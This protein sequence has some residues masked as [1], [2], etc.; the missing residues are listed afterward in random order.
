MCINIRWLNSF[1]TIVSLKFHVSFQTYDL[2]CHINY[3]NDVIN[4]S[5]SYM[6]NILMYFF[7]NLNNSFHVFFIC[8]DRICYVSYDKILYIFQ[9]I[10]WKCKIKW[11]KVVMLLMRS[12]F[13]TNDFSCTI[14][15]EYF[16]VSYYVTEKVWVKGS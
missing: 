2:K 7:L 8:Y 3:D 14:L 6:S 16:W 9:A 10:K 5:S 13:K 1:Y 4:V 12:N 11:E 15:K